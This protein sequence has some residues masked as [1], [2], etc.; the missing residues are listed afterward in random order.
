MTYFLLPDLTYETDELVK[1]ALEHTE[2]IHYGKGRFTIYICQPLRQFII[3][4]AIKFKNPRTLF[5]QIEINLIKA[6]GI[7]LPHTDHDRYVT[8]NLPLK[9]NF[10]NSTVD[11]YKSFSDKVNEVKLRTSDTTHESTAKHYEDVDLVDQVA[12]E[13]PICFD[14]QE[15]HGVTNATNE[16]RYILTLS[17]NKEFTLNKLKEMYE[18]GELLA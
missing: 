10:K 16:D 1:Y 18:S 8:M 4:I 14:T 2:W 13:V 7:V 12:Y 6:N 11:F 17:F 9:G 5:K 15:V 3:P